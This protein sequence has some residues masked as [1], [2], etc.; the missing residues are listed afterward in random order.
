MHCS[1]PYARTELPG[2]RDPGNLLSPV[3]KQERISSPTFCDDE[4]ITSSSFPAYAETESDRFVPD[5]RSHSSKRKGKRNAEI[6]IPRGRKRNARKSYV[7]EATDNG[8]EELE[9]ILES[10]PH[11]K[12]QYQDQRTRSRG[13]NISSVATT[14]PPSE[15]ITMSLDMSTGSSKE[16]HITLTIPAAFQKYHVTII[17]GNITS[18]YTVNG[19]ATASTPR[20]APE[21]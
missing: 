1:D 11:S 7:E 14:A 18:K 8:E 6:A 13:E 3:L 9:S 2:S 16:P 20:H 4:N 21:I 10:A 17:H 15:N 5:N 12:M 19:E